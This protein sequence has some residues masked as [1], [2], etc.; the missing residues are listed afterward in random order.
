MARRGDKS[1]PTGNGY[2]RSE[3]PAVAGEVRTSMKT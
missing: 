3:I 1:V 2:D